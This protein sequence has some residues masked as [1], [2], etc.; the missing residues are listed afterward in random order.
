MSQPDLPP[1]AAPRQS[2]RLRLIL[3]GAIAVCM[4]LAL[5]GWMLVAL[6]GA[7][8]ERLAVAEL[9]VQLDHLIAGLE[10]DP[11]SGA[12]IQTA[13]P[14]DPRFDLPFGGRY[15]QIAAPDGTLLRSRSLWD[16]S[17]PLPADT[18]ADGAEHVH[19]MDALSGTQ[20]LV[21]ERMVTLPQALGGG[22]VRLAVAM[23]AADLLAARAAF[24]RDIAPYLAGLA[25]IL[26][27]AGWAQVTIGLRPLSDIG[28]RV[29]AI[30]SGEAARLGTDL[31]AEIR[32]LAEEIDALLGQ[33]EAE[34]TRARNRAGDLAH[35]LKTPLQALL[36]EAGRLREGGQT[37]AAEAIDEIAGAM[38]RHVE[39]ELIRARIAS[40]DRH[41][42]A[43][44]SEVVTRI[45]SVIRRTPDGAE[46]AFKTDLPAGLRVAADPADLTEALGAL[47]ENATRHAR[48]EIHLSA[49]AEAGRI[50]LTIRDDGPGI[51]PDRIATLRSRGARA[52]TQG[53]GLGLGIADEIIAALGGAMDLGNANPG[54]RIDLSLPAA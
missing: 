23:D 26:I 7:H 46:R 3:A 51:A 48:H 31:P 32:P 52:D 12:L 1:T 40:G 6:F 5:A 50:R 37:T 27:A 21:S 53:H 42:R 17:L 54:L 47:L 30:R 35:G 44:L 49:R 13:P 11:A 29:A 34:L 33:R 43:D 19:K 15:W 45:I 14:G 18:L 36:G 41:G 38:R 24:L 20:L 16:A 39:H 22:R 25:A 2:L 28:R 4:A 10:T 9:S 8:A